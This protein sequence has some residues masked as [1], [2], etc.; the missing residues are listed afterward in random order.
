MTRWWETC[1]LGALLLGGPVRAATNTWQGD[2][3]DEWEILQV[4]AGSIPDSTDDVIITTNRTI[5]LSGGIAAVAASVQISKAVPP[6]T[7][8]TVEAPA[9]RRHDLRHPQR[10]CEARHPLHRQRTDEEWNGELD[11]DRCRHRDRDAEPLG[12]N[13]HRPEH[14]G[15]GLGHDDRRNP[16]RPGR[17]RL[18]WHHDPERRN[19]ERTEHPFGRRNQCRRRDRDLH[20]CGDRQRPEPSRSAAGASPHRAR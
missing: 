14:V 18:H 13:D 3:N 20:R 10:Q 6:S 7:I 5:R 16:E 1:L 15:H 11:A 2:N 4:V 9:S 8:A 19:A 17:A 12:R